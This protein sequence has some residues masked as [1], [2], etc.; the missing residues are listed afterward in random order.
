[1]AP[2]LLL[3]GLLPASAA[4]PKAKPDSLLPSAFAGW[5]KSVPA[6]T[7][8]NPAEA[9]KINS[10][11][12]REYGFDDFEDATYT[13]PDRKL[14]VMAIRFKDASGA[15]GAFTFY[16]APEMQTE[17][18]GD[19][20]ASANDR[21]LFY[22]G[23]VLMQAVLDRVTPMSAAELRELA[24]NIPLPTGSA[25]NLPSL[26][27]YLPRQGYV[28]NTA[29]YVVGPLGLANI[30]APIAAE[31]VEFERGAELAQG[32]YNSG[33]GT[34]TLTLIS[35]PT[36]Q[37][38]G[39]RLRALD[40]THPLPQDGST[41]FLTKR[42]GPLVAIVTGAIS[43]RE[44]KSL[45]ASVNYDAEVT[46][47]ERTGLSPRDNV[48]TLLGGVVLLTVIIIGMALVAGIAFGGIRILTKRLFP[49][50]VFDRS[51]DV[52]IIELK[53]R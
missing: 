51:R 46:W 26:P 5:Q 9:D 47:N 16:K 52:E 53:L 3:V 27:M 11:L 19:Q 42:S 21:V 18:I 12:L 24:G 17:K 13:R 32:Q 8:A 40:A 25:R 30:S 7:S 50:R 37:I 28:P 31:Q 39:D 43:Q 33:R 23:N 44:A 45:L 48:G 4:N 1:M 36:P 34:A 20:A 10:E 29:K 49:D 2:I 41:L 38:A 14:Q 15:Y 22:R 6:R 35:Y